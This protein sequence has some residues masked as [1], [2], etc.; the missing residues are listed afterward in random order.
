MLFDE[1]SCAALACFLLS[2]EAS[3]CTSSPTISC[4]SPASVILPT[5]QY[6]KCHADSCS[7][8][9]FALSGVCDE[10]GGTNLGLSKGLIY[11]GRCFGCFRLKKTQS[12]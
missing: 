10:V 1:G 9:W 7:V 5:V 2:D 6:P 4:V 8:C 3:G 12:L 11:D